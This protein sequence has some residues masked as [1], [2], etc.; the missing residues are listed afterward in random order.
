M[1]RLTRS[2]CLSACLAAAHVCAHAQGT[3]LDEDEAVKRAAEYLGEATIYMIAGVT[4]AAEAY[5][6]NNE[7]AEKDRA[8]KARREA[9]EESMLRLTKQVEELQSQVR[10]LMGVNG[11]QA[12]GRRLLSS[13]FS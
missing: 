5:R 4:T 3:L 8:A 11:G 2:D 13:L 10:E 1:R 6:S 12:R 7:K 9:Q